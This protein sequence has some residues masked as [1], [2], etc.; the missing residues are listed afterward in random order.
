MFGPISSFILQKT[1]ALLDVYIVQVKCV[2]YIHHA[3]V[4]YIA[5]YGIYALRHRYIFHYESCFC[6]F[7]R[8]KVGANAC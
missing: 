7:P 4:T 6:A 1:K 3:A 5:A 2:T 8:M